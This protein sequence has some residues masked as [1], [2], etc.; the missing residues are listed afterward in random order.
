MVTTDT[1]DAPRLSDAQLAEMMELM[2]GSD[3]IE[4]KVTVPSD[5]ERAT[6][7]GL[8]MDPVEAQ[9]RQVYFFD[10]PDLALNQAGVVVRARRRTGGRGDTVIKLRPVVPDELPR[11]VRRSASFNV[12]ID[13]L[14]GGFVCS[15]SLKG[16]CTGTEVRDAV[17]GTIPLRDI[18]TKEQRAFYAAHAPKGIDWDSLIVL[19]PT[20]VLKE[21]FLAPTAP[22]PEEPRLFA[23]ELWLY[24]DGSRILELSTRCTP[25]ETYRVGFE[26]KAYLLRQGVSLGGVQQTKTK[27]ALEFFQAQ[28]EA[29]SRNGGSPAKSGRARV[30]A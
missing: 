6:I 16:R 15:G 10:T 18:Y 4:L 11:D 13:I 9:L 22:P 24:P 17:A 25:P 3:S 21:K 12:E 7:S 29:R 14:P 19:G 5:E 1:D 2:K 26:T 30:K 23:I 8:P 27:A 20:F 28:M